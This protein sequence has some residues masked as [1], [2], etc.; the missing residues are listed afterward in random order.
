METIRLTESTRKKVE[1]VLDQ[2]REKLKRHVEF[3]LK[4]YETT[5]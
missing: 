5:L 2:E 1:I 3:N 4:Y